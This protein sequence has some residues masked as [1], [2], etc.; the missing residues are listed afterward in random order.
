[1]KI[2]AVVVTCNRIELLPRA[3]TS[4]RNQKRVADNVFVI[5]N[6][7]VEV[8]ENEEAICKKFGYPL[9]VN[10]RTPNYSGALNTGIEEIIKL[11]G[12]C[13]DVYFAS[14]DDDD[15]WLPSYLHEMEINNTDD[16]DLLIGSLL[17]KSS[18]ENNLQELPGVLNVDNFLV[19]NPGICGSNTFIRISTLLRAGAF[20][21]AAIATV[22]RDLMIR[23]FQLS[24]KYKIID[25]HLITQHTDQDRKRVTTSGEL[26]RKSLRYFYYK[27][28]HLMTDNVNKKFLDRCFK[29][30]DISNTEF[31]AIPSGDIKYYS[32]NLDF[33]SKGDYQFVIGFIAGNEA[34]S[35]RLVEE[36]ILKKVPVDLLIIVDARN[37]GEQG[38]EFE[39]KLNIHKLNHKIIRQGEWKKHLED[40]RY[41]SFFRK[42]TEINSIPLGR[43]ILHHHLF[44]ETLS[45]KKPVFWIVDDDISLCTTNIE[46][47]LNQQ[48]DVFDIINN[49]LGSADAIIGGISSD[50]PIPTLSCIRSQLVD[51]LSSH[52]SQGRMC[53][54]QNNVHKMSDYYYDLSDCHTDHLEN[55]IFSSAITNEDLRSIFSGKAVSRK[56]LQGELSVK[57]TIVSKRGANTIVLNRDLLHYYP[58]INLEIQNKFARRGDLTWALF[59]QIVSGKTILEHSFSIDHNRPISNFDLKK[60]LEKSAYDLVGY[61]FNKGLQSV[62]NKIVDDIS[63]YRAKDILEKLLDKKYSK[64]FEKAYDYFLTKRKTKFLMNYYRILGLT[65]LLS[66]DFEVAEHALEQ[67]RE[68]K[69]LTSFNSILVNGGD[70]AITSFFEILTSIIWSYSNSITELVESDQKH[71]QAVQTQ[72]NIG[73]PILKLGKGSEGIAFTDNI[74]VYKSFYD[75]AEKDWRF[76]RSR[77]ICFGDHP[78][79]EKLELF[80]SGVHRF[81][82]YPFHLFKPISSIS[83]DQLVS[84]FRFCKTNDFIFTNICPKNCIQ[85]IDNNFKL[86]DYGKSFEP[87]NLEK[88]INSTKRGYLLYKFP[89]MEQIEFEK[90]T[91]KINCGEI[92][93]E[94]VDWQHFYNLI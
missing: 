74:S 18:I 11:Y 78:F 81:I 50:P 39:E 76:L 45:F 25:K 87:Y 27:Y 54:D 4:I 59:N 8:R 23:V 17:R 12:V 20:D 22:D 46:T 61:A 55:P 84:F 16:Y 47:L 69:H 3:L 65:Q 77:S 28:Q 26:K 92:P 62:I 91:A 43:S 53:S 41:G 29:L 33:N 56:A 37:E 71:Q 10:S 48:T 21:E 24:P 60:E 90:I 2:A 94:I 93:K 42:Y 19:G 13:S 64:D 30:F 49:H 67:F 34:I 14:L 32:T 72:F 79:L 70:Q 80:E 58:V 35:L 9:L 68:E 38:F 15:E 88:F 31:G 1:M 75:I 63:P 85:T 40:G 82:K 5:S 73:F 66:K 83:L 44:V 52:N 7:D 89:K 6:S 57:N 36:I 86:V 51:F